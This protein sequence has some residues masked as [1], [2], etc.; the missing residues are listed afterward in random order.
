MNELLELSRV[1]RIKNESE[2][3][4]FEALA[5]EA[6]GLVHNALLSVRLRFRAQQKHAPALNRMLAPFAELKPMPESIRA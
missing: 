5:H 4:S 2:L 3:I 1:G 6:V